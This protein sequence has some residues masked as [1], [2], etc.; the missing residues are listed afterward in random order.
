[1]THIGEL[2]LYNYI[3]LKCHEAADKTYLHDKK[4]VEIVKKELAIAKSTQ[5]KY[6]ELL[7]NKTLVFKQPGHRG[8]YQINEKFITIKNT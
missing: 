6:L 8:Y 5:A 4:E 3:L 7:V 1:M 2:R